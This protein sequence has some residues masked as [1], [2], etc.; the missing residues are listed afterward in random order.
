MHLRRGSLRAIEFAYEEKESGIRGEGITGGLEAAGL[1]DT[2]FSIRGQT[3]ENAFDS[4]ILSNAAVVKYATD[5]GDTMIVDMSDGAEWKITKES[6]D[7]CSLG[8]GV[9]IDVSTLSIT[10]GGASLDGPPILSKQNNAA[11]C[12]LT[13]TFAKG[14]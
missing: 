8:M 6:S 12:K 2:D 4:S 9:G 3:G 10:A 14:W 1:L 11:Y 13:A 5:P 7:R